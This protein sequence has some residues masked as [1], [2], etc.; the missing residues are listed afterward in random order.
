MSQP[1]KHWTDTCL[2][3]HTRCWWHT[4]GTNPEQKSPHSTVL[5]GVLLLSRE[6]MDMAML[7]LKER[8]WF[9][10]THSFRLS[11]HG[12][13]HPVGSMTAHKQAWSREVAKSS[14]SGSVGNRKRERDSGPVMIFETSKSPSGAVQPNL[15][16][17]CDRLPNGFLNGAA[18][19]TMLTWQ[20]AAGHRIDRAG[21]RCIGAACRL[22]SLSCCWFFGWFLVL[23]CQL[24]MQ[25][26]WSSLEILSFLNIFP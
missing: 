9:G 10:L 18:L 5:V 17:A 24:A 1:L 6:A 8:I 14:T 23:L 3:P 15:G 26:L 19:K 2:C 12:H 11:A 25:Q 4:K 20:A 16:S 7:L 13:Y 22:F 21:L